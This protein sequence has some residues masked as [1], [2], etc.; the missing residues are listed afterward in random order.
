MITCYWKGCAG[1]GSAELRDKN[2][3]VWTR[4]CAVHVKELDEAIQS[5]S[6][7]RVMRA[8]VLAHGGAAKAAKCV[9]Q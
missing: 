1:N 4:L 8:W 7:R 6:P 5:L 9:Y 2:G 3:D